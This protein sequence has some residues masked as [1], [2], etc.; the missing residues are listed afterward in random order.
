MAMPKFL[1]GIFGEPKKAGEVDIPKF[2]NSILELSPSAK[3]S[4]AQQKA[5]V[6][7]ANEPPEAHK[8]PVAPWPSIDRY[9]VILGSNV[10]ITYI[11]NIFRICLTGYRREYCDLL[12]DLLERDP[13]TYAVIAQ[14][15]HA[16]TGSRLQLIAAPTE[17]GSENEKRAEIIRLSVERRLHKIAELQKALSLMQWAGLYYAVGA[18][19]INWQRETVED[20]ELD[21][22]GWQP[23]MLHWI[24]SRRLNYPEPNSW[25]VRIWD[26]GGVMSSVPGDDPTG[27]FFGIKPEMFP[28]KFIIHT[29]TVRGNYPTRDGL[30]RET[31]FWSALKLMGARGASNYIERFG[32]PWVAGYYSTSNGSTGPG[33][34]GAHRIATTE[35]VQALEAAAGALGIGSLSGATLPDSTK[36]DIF[37]PAASTPGRQLFH[38]QFIDLCNEEISKA[39]LGQSDTTTAGPNGSRAATETRKEGTKELYR[40]DA[41]CLQDTL[42]RGLIKWI[43]LLNFPGEEHLTPRLLIQVGEEPSLDALLERA[44]KA[45]EAGAPVDADMICE[46]AGIPVI[47]KP[48]PQKMLDDQIAADKLEDDQAELDHAAATEQDAAAH[49]AQQSSLADQ[50]KTLGATHTPVAHTPKKLVKKLR[51]ERKLEDFANNSRRLFPLAPMKPYEV[52]DLIK[53]DKG[54]PLTAPPK[55]LPATAEGGPGAAVPVRG[56]ESTPPIKGPPTG[57]SGS[58][59]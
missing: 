36:L 9:P 15:V 6:A 3:L 46:E 21:G 32:K 30:G 48:D 11:A 24:H 45:A 47:P 38:K 28:G 14:R 18:A 31:A 58:S 37:G 26:Q 44:I 25:S 34:E 57:P 5:V 17:V 42:E 22:E 54:T 40:Y 56:A 51:P 27:Q 4:P 33:S 10:T 12:D 19:E 59:K 55:I 23:A 43:T 13:H 8:A 2:D 29:P 20:A 7:R 1:Q 41:A 52:N 16:V 49:A 39:V 50:A 35:D 53:M